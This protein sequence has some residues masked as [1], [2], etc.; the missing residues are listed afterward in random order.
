MARGT[1]LLLTIVLSVQIVR[2]NPPS[3]KSPKTLID[4]EDNLKF[5]LDELAPS[6]LQ[7]RELGTVLLIIKNQLK[8][9]IKEILKEGCSLVKSILYQCKMHLLK[10]FESYTMANVLRVII[11]G[12]S[13]MF[14]DP[15]LSF[16]ELEEESVA[17]KPVQLETY[18]YKNPYYPTGLATLF[19]NKRQYNIS[20]SVA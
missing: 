16:D 19:R 2:S 7:K 1:I 9:I 15:E 8:E 11:S 3:S 14:S 20:S 18:N 5:D 17:V 4:T 13:S 6:N 12:V 10:K